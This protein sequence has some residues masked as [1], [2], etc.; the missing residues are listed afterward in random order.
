MFRER[1]PSLVSFFSSSCCPQNSRLAVFCVRIL[2]IFLLSFFKFFKLQQVR[3]PVTNR[4]ISAPLKTLQLMWSQKRKGGAGIIR[5][6]WLWEKIF[7]I[8][9]KSEICW[10]RWSWAWDAQVFAEGAK[11]QAFNITTNQVNYITN[12][13]DYIINEVNYIFSYDINYLCICLKISGRKDCWKI[14]S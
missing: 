2:P 6:T 12:Q 7:S 8:W 14:A 13:V 5:T 9:K 3:R 10:E 11:S 4:Q 1:L